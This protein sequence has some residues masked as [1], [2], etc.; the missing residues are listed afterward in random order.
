[1]TIS[2]IDTYEIPV[3]LFYQVISVNED[4]TE[5]YSSIIF[6]VCF[7]QVDSTA[8]LA[9][10]GEDSL[11]SGS[12]YGIFDGTVGDKAITGFLPG[13]HSITSTLSFNLTTLNLF[14]NGLINNPLEY[15]S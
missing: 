2:A 7:S 4:H 12:T 11:T 15:H 6:S 1:M 10:W 13:W 3:N 14:A 9:F 5:R 8:P